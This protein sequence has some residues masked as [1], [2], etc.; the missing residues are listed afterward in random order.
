MYGLPQIML[1]KTTT[2]CFLCGSLLLALGAVVMSG[3]HVNSQTLIQIHPTF[4]PMQY[5]TALGFLLS[6]AAIL[7]LIKNFYRATQTLG[8]II[9]FLGFA[10][11]LEYM[12]HLDMGIDQ[13]FMDQSIMTRTSHPGRMA[14]NTALCFSLTGLFFIL[15]RD[16]N[17][18]GIGLSVAILVFST[19]ALA[20]YMLQNDS[21]YGWGNLTRMAIHTSLGFITIGFCLS[22]IFA[23]RN[24]NLNWQRSLPISVAFVTLAITIF[25]WQTVRDTTN[26]KNQ[27]YFQEITADTKQNLQTVYKAYE[28][29][30]WGGLGLFYASKSVEP[31]EWGKFVGALQIEDKL[32]GING[33]GYIDYVQE[34]QLEQ[35]LEET[36]QD[37]PAF[38]NKPRTTFSDKFV[39]RYI[40]PFEKNIQAVGLDIGFEENRRAAAE[41]ARDTG[42][43]ALTRKIILVQDQEKEPGFLLLLP[44]YED[45]ITP[46]TIKERREKIVGWVYAPFI[47]KDLFGN[48]KG[49]DD[50]KLS[51]QVYDGE[52]IKQENLIYAS[53]AREEKASFTHQDQIIVAGQKWTINWQNSQTFEPPIKQNTAYFI[54]LLGTLFSMFLFYVLHR[55]ISTQEKISEEVDIKTREVKSSA[56]LLELV[57]K[58][59]PDLIFVKDTQ[60]RIVSANKAFLKLYP[61]KKRNTIIGT[62]TLEKHKKEEAEEFLKDDRKAFAEGKVTTEETITFPNGNIRTLLTQK[63]RFEDAKGEKFIL[64]VANDITDRKQSEL[65]LMRSNSELERFAYIASHDL[66]EPLRM[67]SNFTDLLNVEYAKDLDETASQYMS[68]IMDAASRMQALI[69][70]ILEYSRLESEEI[71]WTEFNA[72][73]SIVVALKN[74]KGPIDETEAKI[75]VG[76]MPTVY[77]NPI[78]FSRLMQNLIGNAIKYRDAERTLEIDI[79]CEERDNEWLFKVKDNAIGIEEKYLDQIFVIFKRLH[80]KDEYG[81]TGIGLAICKKIIESFGGKLSVTSQHGVGSE[82]SFSIPKK[83]IDA[84]TESKTNESSQTN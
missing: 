68:F 32:P 9:G 20:G 2:Y 73:N 31:Y 77:A 72:M 71:G 27:A 22:L 44:R 15:G 8:L 30:L 49:H 29:S 17:K 78:R 13:L 76:K 3:W 35:Y 54:L 24:K 19:M 52:T 14:P 63:I 40:E 80:N 67:I 33:I 10:T 65:E 60:F 56:A 16:K 46:T 41:K 84:S 59:I 4:A 23:Q 42:Q 28:Q 81:G 39:I 43:P 79:S 70:D 55:L 45:N 38:K 64:G 1:E 66:Q 25:A 21:I 61:E 37:I 12:F 26:A 74:L 5:N 53:N 57:Y 75:S 11:V 7:C 34:S 83:V 18:L 48:L 82:F 47:G 36:R 58:T 69:A 6:G 50:N 62:T 51:Y